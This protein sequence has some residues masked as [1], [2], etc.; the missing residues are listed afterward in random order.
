MQTSRSKSRRLLIQRLY[1]QIYGEL[2]EGTFHESFFE[3]RFNF[4]PD[5]SYIETMEKII[6]SHQKEF[7]AI[8]QKIAPKF[9]TDTMLYTNILALMIGI[10]EMLY[11]PE[12]IPAKVSINEA[13][14]LAKY[15]GDENSKNIVNAILHTF[16]KTIDTYK[17]INTQ[18]I[19]NFFYK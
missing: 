9:Q 15:F 12:E 19:Q 17:S 4:S 6:L 1:S 3:G 16:F 5:I 2:H 14:D 11:Y 10:A 18:N 8:I 7:I 13:I